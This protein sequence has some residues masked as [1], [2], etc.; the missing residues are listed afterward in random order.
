MRIPHA[1]ASAA[2]RPLPSA[3]VA[4]LLLAAL[5]SI[6]QR[7]QATTGVLR[8][9]MP[10]GTSLYTNKSCGDVGGKAVP[11]PAEVL[12]RIARERRYEA[13]LSGVPEDM[14]AGVAPRMAQPGQRRAVAS[15]CARDPRQLALDL[16]ASLALGDVNRV[17]ESF[18]WAGMRNA[19][20]QAVM[21]QL[22]RLTAREAL[23]D[24]EF[25]DAQLGAVDEAGL[26]QVTFESDGA[27]RVDAFDVSLDSGCYFLR[28]A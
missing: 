20:A 10:D 26:M 28:Y 18:D 11:L 22:G 8:C 15:G 16:Q 4:T 17:A 24:A 25:F 21:D 23:V 7:A 9:Q 13:R 1:T 27:T 19:Q 6:P 2:M 12:A 3:L 14:L 5:P